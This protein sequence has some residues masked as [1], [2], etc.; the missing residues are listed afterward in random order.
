[1]DE[2]KEGVEKFSEINGFHLEN[3]DKLTRVI[4]GDMNRGGMLSGGLGED[5]TPELVLANYDK[6]AG[7][8]TKD[9]VKIKLGSFWDFKK[10]APR[11]NPGVMF[12]FNVSGDKVEV[13]DPKN[14]A[15]AISTVSV[16]RAKKEEA[17]KAKKAKS[18]FKKL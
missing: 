16:A 14:L 6:L 17:V 12:V 10:K 9:G 5:A 8:I 1:M 3:P 15:A 13:D 4:Y 18:K 7:Y 11:E 2:T